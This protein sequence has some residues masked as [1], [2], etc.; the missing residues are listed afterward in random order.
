MFRAIVDDH[1]ERYLVAK[2]RQD[3]SMVITNIFDVINT[4]G[5]FLMKVSRESVYWIL[6]T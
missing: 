5:G 6:H 1:V 4:K 2:T 3:K